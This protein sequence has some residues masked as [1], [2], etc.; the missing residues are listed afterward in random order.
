MIGIIKMCA[1]KKK[2][3]EI[4][5]R[6]TSNQ[7]ISYRYRTVVK[8]NKGFISSRS[9]HTLLHTLWNKKE[10]P[11]R[12]FIL[13]YI[14]FFRSRISILFVLRSLLRTITPYV[15]SISVRSKYRCRYAKKVNYNKITGYKIKEYHRL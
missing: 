12:Y 11:S 7:K 3:L 15:C 9:A 8:N 13:L 5:L 4:I 1:R 6:K 2:D 10:V 14:S